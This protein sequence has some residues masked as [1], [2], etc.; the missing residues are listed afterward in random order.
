MTGTSS[1][2]LGSPKTSLEK[3]RSIQSKGGLISSQKQDMKMLGRKGGRAAQQSG[4][5]HS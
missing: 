1:R 5:A 3:K 4:R 2:G